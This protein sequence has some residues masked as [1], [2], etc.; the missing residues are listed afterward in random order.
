MSIFWRRLLDRWFPA[1]DSERL[2]SAIEGARIELLGRTSGAEPQGW[3][4]VADRSLALAHKHYEA[5]QY[6]IAWH[7]VKA[8]ERAMLCDPNDKAGAM[9]RAATL[10]REAEELHG[11]RAKA[12]HDLLIGADGKLDP[13]LANQPQRIAEAARLRDDFFDT[14]YFRIDLRRRHLL[15]LFWILLAALAALLALTYWAHIEPFV[16][17]TTPDF[18]G[19]LVTVVL[20][21]VIGASL[22]VAQTIAASDVNTK[23]A[24]QQVGAFM[25]WM[26]PAIGATAA[27]AA[28]VLLLANTKLKVLSVDL[29]QDFSL[30]AVIALVAG[31]SE[32]FIVGALNK[33]ADSQG[34]GGKATDQPS[35]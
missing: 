2:L 32:R 8:A 5:A 22:S 34:G 6:Q 23:I 7:E 26:R 21:G 4:F 24:A 11:R 35:R 28:Y 9:S 19:R 33:V 1:P 30:V 31:F 20:L 27:V 10:A 29:S 3:A 25:A 16:A 12:M 17:S 18:A 15:N 13:E 14:Q